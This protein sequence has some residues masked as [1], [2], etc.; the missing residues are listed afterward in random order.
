MKKFT[1]P[2]LRLFLLA[3]I[4]PSCSHKPTETVANDEAAIVVNLAPVQTGNYALPVTSSGLITT[5]TEAKLSFKIAGVISRI[6][7]E[8]G[9]TVSKGQLLASLD[10]TEIGAQVD[11]ARNNQDKA[12]RDLDRTKRLL[13]DSAATLEQVQNAAT[14]FDVAGEAYNIAAFNR[15]YSEIRATTSGKILKKYV[16]EGELVTPGNP[17]LLMNSA[18]QN[19]WIVKV[20]LADVDWVRVKKADP[21]SVVTDAYPGISFNA[22]VSLLGEGADAVNGLYPAEVKINTSQHKLASGLFAK[23]V[24]QPSQKAALRSIPVEALVEGNG[25]NSFVFVVNSDQKTVKK[26]PV[27]V[28]YLENNLAFISHGLE[29]VREV[30][31]GGSAFL[32]EFST[33]KIAR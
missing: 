2:L 23:V 1:L 19:E 28:A 15:L 8:E 13:A 7:V 25:N 21:A 30:I 4:L 22:V 31:T 20:G 11:Q 29:Q 33:V 10:L 27:T 5:T 14:A 24:I 9:Q 16:N 12:K 26:I 17:V 32:T 18:G 3:G 6:L